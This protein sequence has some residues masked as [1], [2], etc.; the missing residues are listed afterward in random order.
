[1]QV[2]DGKM[3]KF[4]NVVHIIKGSVV[5]GA[6]RQYGEMRVFLSFN[7]F[8]GSIKKLH[9]ST[10]RCSQGAPRC[11]VYDE[12]ER[13]PSGDYDDD[14][15]DDDATSASDDDDHDTNSNPGNNVVE[16]S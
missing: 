9:D 14:D 3:W 4:S 11:E 15:D 12:N 16:V 6:E 10:F 1:M 13:H 7:G 5:I 8:F 2:S